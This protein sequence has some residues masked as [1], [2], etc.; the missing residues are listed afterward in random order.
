MCPSIDITAGWVRYLSVT[1][2]MTI[3]CWRWRV[4]R[5]VLDH[6]NHS[7][8][9]QMALQSLTVL[10]TNDITCGKQKFLAAVSVKIHI[11]FHSVVKGVMSIHPHA[12]SQAWGTVW[13]KNVDSSIVASGSEVSILCSPQLTCRNRCLSYTPFGVGH[14]FF[15]L[16]HLIVIHFGKASG[17][18]SASIPCNCVHTNKSAQHCL[19]KEPGDFVLSVE[20]FLLWTL[21]Q[22]RL[23]GTS[24]REVPSV[25]LIGIGY[26]SYVQRD[27]VNSLPMRPG[28]AP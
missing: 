11:C 16:N 14:F 3:S 10:F 28:N 9:T 24:E 26:V 8:L 15:F 6:L 20:N 5:P 22:P 17:V 23:S 25:R 4:W 13:N 19:D 27:T 2:A 12:C 18:C 1:M 21:T 7:S